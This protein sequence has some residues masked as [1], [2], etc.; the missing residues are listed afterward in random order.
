MVFDFFNVVTGDLPL[1]LDIQFF[2]TIPKCSYFVHTQTQFFGFSTPNNLLVTPWLKSRESLSYC[3]PT[4]YAYSLVMEIITTRMCAY[5]LFH[6]PGM[7]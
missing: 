2:F 1:K 5:I 7:R 3:I 6:A 4:F